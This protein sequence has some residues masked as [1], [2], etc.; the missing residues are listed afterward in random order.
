[1][2][3]MLL[4]MW[5]VAPVD[6][7]QLRLFCAGEPVA[8]HASTTQE[9]IAIFETT[10]DLLPSEVAAHECIEQLTLRIS[11]RSN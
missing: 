11:T 6:G 7:C 4:V 10:A 5:A 2:A 1:V 8:A 3:S 9:L